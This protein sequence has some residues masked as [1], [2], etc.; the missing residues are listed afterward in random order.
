MDRGTVRLE[1]V[2][3]DPDECD[4]VAVIIHGGKPGGPVRPAWTDPAYLVMAPFRRAIR[5]ASRGRIATVQVFVPG[6]GWDVEGPANPPALRRALA[7]VSG[8]FP[9]RPLHLVGHSSGAWV[10][11]QVADEPLVRSV[12]ALAPYLGAAEPVEHLRGRSVLVLHG[13][14]DRVTS[15]ERSESF[16]LR[17]QAAGGNASLVPMPG[18]HLLARQAA[19]WRRRVAAHAVGSLMG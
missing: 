7:E 17:L 18:G 15:F 5:T 12:T 6:G 13:V 11:V 9:G 8:R 3:G 14:R 1:H 10:A 4:G 19:A 2:E 16:V